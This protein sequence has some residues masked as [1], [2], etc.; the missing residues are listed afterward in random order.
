MKLAEKTDC[1]RVSWI[2]GLSG[3]GKTTLARA[4]IKKIPEAILLDGDDLREVLGA[5]S[6]GFDAESRKRLA[7]IYSRFAGLLA[8]QGKTVIVAT[9]S[10]FHEVH[11]LNHE[12]LPRYLEVFLDVPE[13][14]RRLR[15]PK[16]LYA[17]EKS[18]KVTRMAGSEL[19]VDFPRR[20]DLVLSGEYKVDE[21]VWKILKIC[22]YLFK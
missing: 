5:T 4:L 2:T 21:A 9:I 20:P 3:A 14:I 19:K 11:K 6:T 12:N 8:K 1:G 17:G 13:D 22:K 10:L 16:G 7:L 18:G 15:D